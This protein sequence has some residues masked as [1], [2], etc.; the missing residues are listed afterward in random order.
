MFSFTK[1]TIETN[2]NKIIIS[3]IN[4][5]YLIA[6]INKQ[7][8]TSRIKNYLV[9]ESGRRRISF[10]SFFALDFYHLM[11]TLIYHRPYGVDVKQCE[12]I[13]SL[14]KKHTWLA[15]LDTP[16]KKRFN[17][18]RLKDFVYKPLPHQEEVFE[19]YETV[20][21]KLNLKGALINAAPGT[22]KTYTSLAIAQ[23]LDVDTVVVIC[24]NN[25]VTRVWEASIA[26]GKE[27][28][29]K[30]NNPVWTSH[31][32][33]PYN[34]EKYLVFHYEALGH[35]LDM[36][37][38]IKKRG[39]GIVILD[40]NHNLNEINSNRTLRFIALCE[41]LKFDDVIFMS[42]TPLKAMSNEL[43]PFFRVC[44]PTFTEHVEVRFKNLFK[45]NATSNAATDLLTR[46]LDY[47]SF[48]VDKTATNVAEPIEETIKIKIPNG[49]HYTLTA[50]AE[51]MAEY[52]EEQQKYYEELK[53]EAEKLFYQCVQS[54]KEYELATH[55]N[56]KEQRAIGLDYDTYLTN[57]D[58]IIRAYH[59]RQLM[60]VN[61][62]M[63]WCTRFEKTR[64]LPTLSSELKKEFIQVKS[65][66][67]YVDLKIRGEC[68]GRVVGG[69][70][71]N[72]HVEIARYI[73]YPAIINSTKKKTLIFSSYNDVC[74]EVLNQT[75]TLKYQPLGV[76]G[77][78][79]KDL[80]SIV[81]R[82]ATDKDANP[83]VATYASLSTA[84]PL[85]MADTMIIINPPFRDY[86]MKQ[87]IAR[88]ARIGQTTQ[89]K[90]YHIM[91][92]TDE[93]ANISTRNIDIMEWS[94]KQVNDILG[95]GNYVESGENEGGIP[96]DV[97]V[98]GLA[99]EALIAEKL[100]YFKDAK[101]AIESR[102]SVLLGW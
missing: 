49:E 6:A 38:E 27:S 13:Q 43:I 84:V 16:P 19:Y 80:S 25:A 95:L 7:W 82:F 65:I 75:K 81:N 77:D 76:F 102:G 57:I 42:G 59:K 86:V 96:S 33:R 48:Y 53:P 73:D 21:Q 87:T 88:V 62:Q 24:P 10:F 37:K 89:T 26:P 56:S 71:I 39:R 1:P 97:V 85:V 36:V 91:L 74:Q 23:M 5:K 44:D 54:A 101:P 63:A 8:G 72:A 93:V 58:V 78:T 4:G 68:L 92:D 70:R 40:E 35:A 41:M 99:Q 11:E 30:V 60:T 29:F 98:M 51:Q 22:G 83:L 64:I 20:P 32:N 9:S 67:K 46:R 14:L 100:S 18:D 50:I 3:G 94:R 61:E 52:I 79:T 28:L 34:N 45:G 2:G 69:A 12:E 15:S 66:V 55:P 47:A 17:R 90:I 31:Q